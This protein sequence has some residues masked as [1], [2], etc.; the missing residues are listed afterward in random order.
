MLT[1]EDIQKIIEAQR[2]IFATKEDSSKL[3]IEIVNIKETMATKEDF[4]RLEGQF[5]RLVDSIDKYA[6]KV[7]DCYQEMVARIVSLTVMKDGASLSLKS[8]ILN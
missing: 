6:K 1:H 8:L 7:D 4:S 3:S 2:G 5:N